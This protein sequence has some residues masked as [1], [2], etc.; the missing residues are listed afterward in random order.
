MAQRLGRGIALLFHIRGT[1]RG[2]SGQQ[3]ASAALY[4]RGRPG[5]NF[6]AGW[7]GP[8]AGSG[9]AKNFVTTGIRSRTVQP[10]SSVAIPTELPVPCYVMWSSGFTRWSGSYYK[11]HVV[12]CLQIHWIER[13]RETGRHFLPDKELDIEAKPQAKTRQFWNVMQN[14]GLENVGAARKMILALQGRAVTVIITLIN[15]VHTAYILLYQVHRS[16]ITTICC[17]RFIVLT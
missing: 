16:G 11:W 10:R 3:H 7:V 17:T 14:F 15:V 1:R 9:R 12:S 4:P 2:V 6:T 13:H 5:T 8:R